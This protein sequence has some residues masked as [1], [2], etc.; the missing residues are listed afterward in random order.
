MNSNARPAERELKLNL[1]S[2]PRFA[3]GWVNVD[4]ALGA[5]LAKVPGF[6]SLNRRLGLFRLDWDHRIRLHDLTRPFPWPGRSAAAIYCSHTLEHMTR[7]R[8]GIF[9]TECARVLRPGGVLRVVVPDLAA[10]VERYRSGALPADELVDA[11]DVLHTDNP[12]LLKRRLASW[13]QHPHRCMYDTPSLV[14]AL[15][16]VGLTAAPRAP[17]DSDIPDLRAIEREDRTR[18]AAIAEGRKV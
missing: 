6:R 7:Q 8:G 10:I 13:V 14:R 3:D 16:D 11:L 1:G 9:L 12:S 5:C 2:G 17:F 18:D 15:H 4:F